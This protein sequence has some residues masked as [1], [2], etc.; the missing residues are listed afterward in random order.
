MVFRKTEAGIQRAENKRA[1]ILTAALEHISDVGWPSFDGHVV[2]ANV[3]MAT[4]TIYVYFNSMSELVNEAI[5]LLAYADAQAMVSGNADPVERY[6]R[7][8]RVL[9]I[10][11]NPQRVATQASTHPVYRTA[12]Q[13]VLEDAI[14]HACDG[15]MYAACP[16][17]LLATAVYGA[18]FGVLAHDPSPNSKTQRVISA[19]ALRMIQAPDMAHA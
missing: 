8:V 17:S 18:I 16:A 6:T 14:V 1:R 10:R 19:M 5:G 11:S 15:K 7:A 13:R 3:Q 12:I 2:A 4:G 9:I